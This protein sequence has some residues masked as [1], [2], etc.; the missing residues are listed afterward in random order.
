MATPRKRLD[1]GIYYDLPAEAY[2][3]DPCVQPSLSR[4]VAFTLAQRSA[5]SGWLEHPRLN[6]NFKPRV[7]T[8]EM[9]FGT[10]A[11]EI[12]LCDEQRIV[13]VKEK[14]WK[15]KAAQLVRAAAK[16]EGKIAALSHQLEKARLLRQYALVQ[17]KAAG[18]LD[19]FTR[20][21]S[22]VTVI[23]KRDDVYLRARFDK[24]LID[25]PEEKSQR[26]HSEVAVWF[27]VKITHDANPAIVGRVVGDKGYDLQRVFYV[28]V[29]SCFEKRFAGKVR[30]VFLFIEPN[31]PFLLSPGELTNVSLAI[32]TS[33]Y[34]RALAR[35][36]RGRSK[37]E[38]PGYCEGQGAF[39]IDAPVYLQRQELEDRAELYSQ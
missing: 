6:P 4:S 19:E 2:H 34:D 11:H 15:G 28:D 5:L 18:F 17:I 33:R 13:E 10:L 31:A 22:E 12:I 29:L 36:K 20:A 14:S 39:M 26:M 37:G 35:W 8:P 32:G 38:W 9:E 21:K 25:P 24:L 3:A 1:V 30:V 23:A 7:S 16:A 27:E